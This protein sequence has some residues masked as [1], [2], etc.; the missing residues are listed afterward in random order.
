MSDIKYVINFDYPNNS[1]D[2]VHRI[3]RTG[4]QEKTVR[5][6]L[7]ILYNF[8]YIKGTSYTFFTPQNA[9]KAN[10]LIKVLEEARQ[11]V[12]DRLRDFSNSAMGNRDRGKRR[13]RPVDE[14][15]SSAPKRGRPTAGASAGRG[16]GTVGSGGFGGGNNSWDNSNDGFNNS[17]W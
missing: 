8:K 9:P 1:E 4:R 6:N 15:G 2:Y 7:K 14:N 16:G 17:R 11:I 12:P 10:D 13:W 5:I 3:G